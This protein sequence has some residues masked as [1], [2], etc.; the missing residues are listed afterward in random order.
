MKSVKSAQSTVAIAQRKHQRR[1]QSEEIPAYLAA[2][3]PKYPLWLGSP[4]PSR[5]GNK[6]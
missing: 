6:H 1:R 4:R 3:D 5:P 2:A